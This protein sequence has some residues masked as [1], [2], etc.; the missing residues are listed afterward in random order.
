MN[1]TQILDL[2]C[3]CFVVG[4]ERV[5]SQILSSLPLFRKKDCV[6]YS[7]AQKLARAG[8]I[9]IEQNGLNYFVVS[10][11]DFDE[12]TYATFYVKGQKDQ[13]RTIFTI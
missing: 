13:N 12:T 10:F 1:Y 5:K 8:H 6:V 7:A 9:V 11:T 2:V 3:A 4:N